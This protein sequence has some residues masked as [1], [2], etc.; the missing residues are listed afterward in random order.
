MKSDLGLTN[1]VVEWV[2]VT[3]EDRF[4]AVG[5]GKIDLLCG[6]ASATLAR[7]KEV[8]FSIPIFPGGIAA[9]LRSDTPQVLRDVLESRPAT[10]PIWRGSPAQVL[11]GKTFSVVDGTTGA[12]WLW[13]RLKDFQL[14]ATV[15]PVADYEAGAQGLLDRKSDVFFGDR[16]ILAEAA[17]ANPSASDL[18]ILDRVF[19]SEPIAL[20]LAKNDDDFRL[21]VDRALS[22][23]FASAEFRTLYAKWFGAP[24]DAAKTF[25][26]QS[27]LPD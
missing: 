20:S 10:G 3:V 19:T 14:A 8:A 5:A 25:F 11:T 22:H 12:D 2:P 9:M 17:A 26:L 13:A 6:A 23:F 24:D 15:V 1:L 21:V 4:A 7:R 27:A 16:A 18:I